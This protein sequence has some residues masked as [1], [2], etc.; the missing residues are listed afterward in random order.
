MENKIETIVEEYSANKINRRD[1]F[2]RLIAI[3]GT[4][5]T[6]QLFLERSGL[7]QTVV[8]KVESQKIDVDSNTVDYLNGDVKLS[9][10]LSKPKKKGKYPAILVIH[11]NRGLNDHTRD[12]ARRFAAEGFVALAVDALSRKGGTASFDT[13]E[14]IREAF[15]TIPA[16]DVISDLNAGLTFLN[17]HKNVKKNKLA[18]IGFCWGGARSFLLAASENKLKAAVVFYGT[19]PTETELAKVN[20]PVFGIYGETDERITSKVPEVDASMKKLKKQYEY[21]IYKAAQHAFFND[22]NQ[23]RYN[24]EAAKDAWIQTLAFLRKNLK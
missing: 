19:A 5:A 21:K 15:N 11:E 9:G 24:A 16:S 17:S 2:T 1:F 6:A 14:K 3:T 8:S 4:Y 18:S 10:Y 7:A 22:T 12:V 23:Q 13:P 20:C